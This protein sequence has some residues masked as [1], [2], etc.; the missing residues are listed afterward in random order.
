MSAGYE[1]A[2]QYFVKNLKYVSLISVPALIYTVYLLS[3]ML[4]HTF[5]DVNIP[6]EYR[7]AANVLLTQEFLKGNNIYSAEALKGELPPM[8]YLY[9]PLYS[10]VTAFFGIFIHIDIVLLHYMVTFACIVGSAVLSADLVRRHTKSLAAPVLAFLFTLNCHWRYSYVNANPDSMALFMM[11]LIIYLL[12]REKIKYKAL[13]TGVLTVLIFFTKQY[14]LL[15]A[16]T[17]TAYLFLFESKKESFKFLGSMA[18]TGGLIAAFLQWKCPLFWTY[19][20]YLAKGPGKGVS[21]TV[22]RGT[23]KMSGEAY[24]LS[25]IMSI[26]GMFL[27]FFIAATVLVLYCIFKKKLQKIDFLLFG[28][29]AV[30]GICLLYIGKNDGAWLSYYLELFVPAL[31]MEALILMERFIPEKVRSWKYVV[32]VGFYFLIFAFTCYRTDHRLPASQMSTEDYKAWSEAVSIMDENQGD[33]YLYPLLAFYGMKHDNYI[34]NTGQPF[35]V[36]Q[37]F[38]DRY[39]KSDSA[40]DKFPYAGDVFS[41]HLEY[42]EKIKEKVRNGEYSLVSYIKDY[43]TVFDED[44]LSLKYEKAKSLTLRA[45]RWTWDVKFYHLK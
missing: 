21:G 13:I 16:G 27:F 42:R 11:I 9:G 37:K 34:Y 38:Y 6:N 26:G 24:N 10:L 45:G 15:V 12:S 43:D 44:D 8:I 22:T 32:F 29:M 5:A 2:R 14:F 23:V 28:H 4:G 41:S 30:S 31:I 18:V 19:S 33:M 20:I 35:V 40:K 1:S 25:Q 17:A 39:L 36:T 3:K 7:E